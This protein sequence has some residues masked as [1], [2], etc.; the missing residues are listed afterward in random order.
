[1][2]VSTHLP[3][4]TGDVR[5]GY[6]VTVRRLPWPKMPP[7]RS[8][9]SGIEPDAPEVAAVNARDAVVA[10]EPLVDERV[11]GS[12]QVEDAAILADE[13]LD[14][15]LGLLPER[16]PQVLVELRKDERVRNCP[17]Q[18]AQV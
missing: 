3:R 1:M 8:A 6:D 18:V 12:E 14:E 5:L 9:T 11:V 16:L 7:R 10:A 13:A 17:A 15:E 4:S 2:F